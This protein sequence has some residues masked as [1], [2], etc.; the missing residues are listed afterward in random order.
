MADLGLNEA[1]HTVEAAKA[2]GITPEMWARFRKDPAFAQRVAAFM[3]Q[4]A[5][6]PTMPEPGYQ[7][8]TPPLR[9]FG[10]EEWQ[11]FFGVVPTNEQWRI[12]KRFPWQGSNVIDEQNCPFWPDREIMETHFAFFAME[13][14]SFRDPLRPPLRL[15]TQGIFDL[16]ERA[17]WKNRPRM[18]NTGWAGHCLLSDLNRDQIAAMKPVET[19]WY[20][21]PMGAI[22]PSKR[23]DGYESTTAA[24]WLLSQVLRYQKYGSFSFLWETFMSNNALCSDY[25]GD[26]APDVKIRV[27][28]DTMG[29]QDTIT[30]GLSTQMEEHE[31]SGM[32]QALSRCLP[33]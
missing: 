4:G 6:T 8:Y 2:A 33:G 27:A 31:L 26:H 13:E 16:R 17:S 23:A 32:G 29:G 10:P 22:H 9:V 11:V 14:V 18:A 20:F 1:Y 12:A 19:R 21:V 7:N 30:I 3:E 25:I 15:N 5:F 24:V 28:T